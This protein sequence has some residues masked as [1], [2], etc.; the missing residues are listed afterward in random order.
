MSKKGFPGRVMVVSHYENTDGSHECL[1]TYQDDA[2]DDERELW[3]GV[4]QTWQ[5]ASDAVW[6]SFW[7]WREETNPDSKGGAG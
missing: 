3:R 7:K 6:R 5:E 2:V 4:G 1:L